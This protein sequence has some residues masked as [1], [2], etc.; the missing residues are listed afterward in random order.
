MP[1]IIL[2]KLNKLKFYDPGLYVFSKHL[3]RKRSH[4]SQ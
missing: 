4:L 3:Y 1:E 2:L